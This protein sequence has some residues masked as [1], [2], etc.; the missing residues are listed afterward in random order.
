M[1]VAAALSHRHFALWV[2]WFVSFAGRFLFVN[3]YPLSNV[4]AL[5]YAF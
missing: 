3:L 5:L 2:V 1:A 4:L